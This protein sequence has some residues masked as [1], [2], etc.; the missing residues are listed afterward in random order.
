LLSYLQLLLVTV[1]I[2]HYRKKIDFA[3]VRAF[4]FKVVGGEQYFFL[5]SYVFICSRVLWHVKAFYDER[6]ESLNQFD[7]FHA[8]LPI[9]TKSVLK[10]F[11]V[12]VFP[13]HQIRTVAVIQMEDIIFAYPKK[14]LKFPFCRIL[15]LPYTTLAFFPLIVIILFLKVP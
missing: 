3:L 11:Y 5:F 15:Q 2:L 6:Q 4:I 10:Y 8:S 7:P 1:L 12:Q 14:N 9:S 13:L